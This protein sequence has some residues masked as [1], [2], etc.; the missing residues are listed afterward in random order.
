MKKAGE[1]RSDYA[2][3]LEPIDV[4]LAGRLRQA[5]ESRGWSRAKLAA[6]IGI[7]EQQITK[8]EL[9]S[10]RMF[11][12]RLY[13]AADALEYPIGWF[14]DG[15]FPARKRPLGKQGDAYDAAAFLTP[16]RRKFLQEFEGLDQESRKAVTSV[17]DALGRVHSGER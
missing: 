3:S 2:E 13:A 9:P 4:Y 7:S 16:D 17:I 5:R 1:K 11:A 8:W 10:N 6:E 12:S 14:F 15:F